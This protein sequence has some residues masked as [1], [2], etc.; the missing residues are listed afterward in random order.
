MPLAM[1]RQFKKQ[2]EPGDCYFIRDNE[3]IKLKTPVVAAEQP[4][5]R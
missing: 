2:I 5:Q 4:S 3:C 1:L